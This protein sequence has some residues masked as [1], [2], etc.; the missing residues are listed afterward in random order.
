MYK[1]MIVEDEML[2]RIGIRNVIKWD[3]LGITLTEDAEN[4][5]QALE[6]YR[7]ERPD[8][9]LTD[10]RMPEMDGMS[11]IRNIRRQ[12]KRCRFLILT[13]VEDFEQAQEAIAYSVS[14]YLLKL[15]MDFKEV[16]KMLQKAVDE[17]SVLP[18]G[19]SYVGMPNLSDA[20]E[21]F[22]KEYF[23]LH[24]CNAR[25]SF[26]EYVTACQLRL[27]EKNLLVGVLTLTFSASYKE[28]RLLSRERMVQS[29]IL[30]V[31]HEFLDREITGEVFHEEGPA[32]IL[33]LNLPDNADY[34]QKLLDF[35]SRSSEIMKMYFGVRFYL[36][37]SN[38]CND[39]SD[40]PNRYQEAVRQS[41]FNPSCPFA[42]TD[43]ELLPFLQEEL[44]KMACN[45]LLFAL[46]DDPDR[47]EYLR[48]LEEICKILPTQPQIRSF[49]INL[50]RFSAYT[51]SR[52][53]HIGRLE[54][55]EEHTE[56]LQHKKHLRD[57]SNDHL[58]YLQLLW[59]QV[60][61][62][63]QFSSEIALTIAYIRKNYGECLSLSQLA[64]YVHLSPNYLSN[65]FKK[66]V[67]YCLSD[68]INALRI[69]KAKFLLLNSRK[70]SHEIATELGFSDPAYFG[71]VFKK[72]TG[73]SPAEYRHMHTNR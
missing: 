53:R 36:N 15:T 58:T 64:A 8:I 50:T 68:Y 5:A 13:C 54:M 18:G 10:L 56:Q 22:F 29:S 11:L 48:Q 52:Q 62:A 66:E 33:L 19:P 21:R 39:Y 59:E 55:L 34:K 2:V 31:L 49:F 45:P 63:G 44:K 12:D 24:N 35:Y 27:K 71:K 61:E 1:A 46:F 28:A 30:D 7:S 37:F 6:L 25:N 38:F 16:E 40:L 47:S 14:G 51:V 23:T 3:T 41:F 65:L 60:C 9:I 69:E 17:L 42:Q 32:Y 20:K 72:S 43:A 70:R 26:R 57:M 67:G 4:G 73:L